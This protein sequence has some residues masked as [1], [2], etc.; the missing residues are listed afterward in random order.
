M[1][2]INASI[3][4]FGFDGRNLFEAQIPLTSD[5]GLYYIA[6]FRIPGTDDTS[7]LI[8]KI[9]IVPHV[10]LEHDGTYLDAHKFM[11][12]SDNLDREC[13]IYRMEKLNTTLADAI[14]VSTSLCGQDCIRIEYKNRVAE[15]PYTGAPFTFETSQNQNG[16]RKKV[17]KR[18]R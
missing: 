7:G 4:H 15:I 3:P 11:V 18:R 6:I 5:Q 13:K 14:D 9:P 8:T 16:G 12:Y 2:K 10:F 17:I 1:D